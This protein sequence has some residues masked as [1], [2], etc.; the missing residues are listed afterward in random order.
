M[1]NKDKILFVVG[2]LNQTTQMHQIASYLKNEYDCYFT[3][4][5]SVNP[6]IYWFIKKGFFHKTIFAGNFA[7]QSQAYLKK[8]GENIDYR[9]LQ[10]LDEY[11]LVYMCTD[12]FIPENLKKHPKIWVQEG[13][14]D[15]SRWRS[16]V[17]KK[18]GLP[19]V[20]G[21]GTALNG[22]SNV[23]DVYC[24]LS[25]GYNHRLKKLGTDED[26]L[27]CTGVPNFDNCVQYLNNDFPHKGHVLVATS[28]I[29]ELGGHEDRLSFIKRCTE[30]AGDKQLIFRLHPNEDKRRAFKEIRA[31]TPPNTLVFTEGNTNHMVANCDIL[32]TQWS[33]V[34]YVGI[35]LGKKIY[36]FF[37][38]DELF[39]QAP[40]QTNGHSAYIIAQLGKEY[41]NH[42]GSKKDLYHKLKSLTT[43]LIDKALL[44]ED[45]NNRASPDRLKQAS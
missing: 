15:Q 24:T 14:I 32:I 16:K 2:S 39:R 18:L 40:L 3:Q 34:V 35:A 44:N 27:I 5:Y 17:V 21:D 11:K 30:I 9:A 23:C 26:K 6:I 20:L 25:E 10:H 33:S 36:S 12:M 1:K 29:R 19:A 45:N 43:Q 42:K 22:S 7:K 38:Q 4:F 28:D 13:M 41:I 37:D 31:I 8:H